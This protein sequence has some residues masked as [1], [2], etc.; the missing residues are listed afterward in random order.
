MAARKP[1]KS[2]KASS[3]SKA[4]DVRA[5]PPAGRRPKNVRPLPGRPEIAKKYDFGFR[6]PPEKNPWIDEGDPEVNG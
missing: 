2:V 4:A 1:A 5:N 6:T 3:A